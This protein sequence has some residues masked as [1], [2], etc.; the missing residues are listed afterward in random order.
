MSARLALTTAT[1][2]NDDDDDDNA[3]DG[4]EQTQLNCALK[5]FPFHRM[6]PVVSSR[7]CQMLVGWLPDG[8]TFVVYTFVLFK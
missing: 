3:S 6:P 5:I 2:D 8:G 1:T 7:V 4:N